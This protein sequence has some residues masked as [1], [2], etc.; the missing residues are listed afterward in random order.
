[1]IL[2]AL[3]AATD[4]AATVDVIE[5]SGARGKFTDTLFG[6]VAVDDVW[7]LIIFSVFLAGTTLLTGTG[8]FADSLGF[9]VTDLG[10]SLFLGAALGIP[11][12]Y[13]T[14]RIRQGEPTLLEALGIVLLCGGLAQW[15]N[16]SYILSAI[17]TGAIVTNLAKHHTYPFHAISN[18]EQPFLVLFFI[19]SGAALSLE[20]F[21]Q[22][23][24]IGIGYLGLRI[25]GRMLGAELST[26]FH[27]TRDPENKWMGLA[28]MPQAGVA[29]GMALVASER[30]PELRELLLPVIIGSTV[31]FELLGPICTRYA[32]FR[33]H[34]L[35]D[36]NNKTEN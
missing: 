27:S 35:P 12:A 31:F 1:L 3:A 13:L 21:A 2:G 32:L 20:S 16:V 9:A 5:E 15:L 25:V 29:L 7:G 36:K 26:H 18:I 28:L 24:M 8:N 17:V 6:V 33:A 4:P 30:Y 22:I 19:L 10:G 14:G 11:A 23:G 34:A